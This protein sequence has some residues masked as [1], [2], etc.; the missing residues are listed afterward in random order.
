MT[1]NPLKKTVSRLVIVHP[2]SVQFVQHDP[3]ASEL[4]IR[5]V[6]GDEMS[7]NDRE[8]PDAIKKMFDKIVF[9]IKHY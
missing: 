4:I 2:K 3:A 7:I 9:Q 6:N 8:D 5:Y 1:V